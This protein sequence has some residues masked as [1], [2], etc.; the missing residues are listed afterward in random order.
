MRWTDP[1]IIGAVAS[2]MV[3]LLGGGALKVI[4]DA[5]QGRHQSRIS[6]AAAAE[7]SASGQ[8]D[9]LT[10]EVT[11]LASRVDELREQSRTQD[12]DIAELR[13]RIGTWVAWAQALV[14]RWDEIRQHPAP[15]TPPWDD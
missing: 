5:W 2:I 10:I 7:T 11:R 12:R 1:T 4:A 3:A 13:H 6:L 8:I 14:A 9:R 15:P